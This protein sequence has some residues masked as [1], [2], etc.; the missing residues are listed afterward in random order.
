MIRF[1]CPQCHKGFQV[2][3]RLAGRTIKCPDCNGPISI[4]VTSASRSSAQLPI[5]AAP[6][7]S[8]PSVPNA[9]RPASAGVP[10]RIGVASGARPNRAQPESHRVADDEDSAGLSTATKVAAGMGGAVCVVAIG[11][12]VWFIAFRDTW[13]LHNASRVSAML[14]EADRLQ[15]A[16]PFKAYKAY[17]EVLNESKKHKITDER[18]S[19]MLANA[20]KS[21]TA[22]YPR[23]QDQ[24]RAEEAEKQRRAQEE[25]RLAEAE[26][27]RR[28]DEENQ[29]R[30]ADAA[31]RIAEE[32]RR[33]ED[34]RRKDAVSVYRNAPQSARNALNVVKKVGARIEVGINYANY[35]SV[36]GEAWGDVKIFVES[37]E[38]KALPD[39][40]DLLVKAV[41]DYKSALNVWQDK[42]NYPSLA[43]GA[44]RLELDVLMQRCWQRAGK[45]TQMAEA[46]LDP[47]LTENTLETIAQVQ[48]DEEDFDEKRHSIL[49]GK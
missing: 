17:E 35:S 3:D 24:I 30:A 49:L 13:E 47:E 23:V 42:I 44:T 46:L 14:E 31:R 41:A 32:K 11:I 20:E 43:S 2:E 5:Q 48:G 27:Q 19:K 39:F 38:G 1:V 28:A 12:L 40:S 33:R 7:S 15:Q 9:V 21:R 37:P 45:R 8:P 10:V 18:F 6:Q 26:K 36:V 34:Q 16:D 25:A 4:P 22:L 29:K